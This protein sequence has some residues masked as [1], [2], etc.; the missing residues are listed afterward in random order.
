MLMDLIPGEVDRDPMGVLIFSSDRA[1][2]NDGFPGS[3]IALF[4]FT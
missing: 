3:I 2:R 1:L 4:S